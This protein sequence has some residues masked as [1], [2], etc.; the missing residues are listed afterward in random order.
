MLIK[1]ECLVWL[2]GAIVHITYQNEG[3]S[4]HKNINQGAT[5]TLV[6]GF[7]THFQFVV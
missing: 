4:H 6:V 3:V 5:L 7:K 2:S 1:F